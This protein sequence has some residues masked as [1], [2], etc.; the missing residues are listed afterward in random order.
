MRKILA[1]D[2]VCIK[3]IVEEG[4][5]CD[6][7]L[8]LDSTYYKFYATVN[9]PPPVGQILNI[10]D[11][12][13]DCIDKGVAFPWILSNSSWVSY[14]DTTG[15]AP[16]AVKL[17]VDHSG[18]NPGE[19]FDTVEVD[20]PAIGAPGIVIVE[21]CVLDEPVKP[22]ADVWITDTCGYKGD[23][24]SVCVNFCNNFDA[25]GITA[26]LIFNNA[27]LTFL[28]GDFVGSRV[29]GIAG[30][31]TLFPDGNRICISAIPFD[32]PP[33]DTGCG[34]LATLYFV[35]AD[36]EGC[37]SATV[38]DSTSF[39][40]V[41]AAGCELLMTDADGN[42]VYPSFAPGSIEIKCPDNCR[43]C[44]LVLDDSGAPLPG[45][46]VDLKDSLGNVIGTTTT[47]AN[48]DWCFGNLNSGEKY[49][50]C[51]NIPGFCEYRSEALYCCSDDPSK[52]LGCI[53]HTIRLEICPEDCGICGVVFSADG[54]T[55]E[56]VEVE[57]RDSLGSPVATVLTDSLGRW[58]FFDL[59]FGA[60]YYAHVDVPGFCEYR[61]D[62]ARCCPVSEKDESG[63]ANVEI[64]LEA[65][66]VP[67][68]IC[69]DVRDVTGAP[70]VGV[71]VNLLD[72]LGAVIATEVTDAN[73]QWC[74]EVLISG[75]KYGVNVIGVPG[76][77]SYR[78]GVLYCCEQRFENICALTEIV[79]EECPDECGFCVYVYQPDGSECN[80]AVVELWDSYPDGSV[81]AVQNGTF[82]FGEYCF[83]ELQPGTTYSV[84][85]RKEGHCPQIVDFTCEDLR[86]GI[87]LEPL[88]EIPI[89][90]YSADWS[91]QN[92]T[93][94]GVPIVPGD[95]IIAMDPDGV[96]C[97][98]TTVT[99]PGEY[100]IHVIGDDLTTGP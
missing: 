79:L 59:V 1:D 96:I 9:Q 51:A 75:D 95:V 67:C 19:Y 47:N 25:T 32:E 92:A 38:I 2:E 54:S 24:V 81:L 10:F 46:A 64:V 44:G 20:A 30:S 72:S 15:T 87:T 17:F 91:S 70:L 14:S 56:G 16:A 84:R 39:F 23:T 11:A 94:D 21:L 89:Q 76:Y 57:L 71:S 40:P 29:E 4:D 82:E 31:L 55:V 8:G 22:V 12:G 13:D 3:L 86:T 62:S 98:V 68:S 7:I 43:L 80:D 41:K 50:V 26:G 97:G 6:P 61:S 58:C 42:P 77:C 49:Y 27:A 37:G 90:P 100:L 33:I 35:I 53:P 60:N 18:L 48:G 28:S 73:G 99:T 88:P 52:D 78:S 5:C 74:F 63:C 65:C 85:V 45:V 69:G 66:P 83:G 34:K 36:D 93:I